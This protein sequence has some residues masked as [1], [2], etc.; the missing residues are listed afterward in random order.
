VKQNTSVKLFPCSFNG[1]VKVPPSKSL[2]HRALICAALSSGESLITNFVYSEDTLATIEALETLGVKFERKDN[3][4]VVHGIKKLKLKSKKVYCNE[5]GSTIRFLIPLFSLTEK[6]IHFIGEPG[7]MKRP[8]SIYEK[9]FTEDNN[10][11]IQDDEKIVVKGSVKAR[12]YTIKG[13]VSSQ[14]FSGLMFA[15][16][17][18][19]EDSEIIIDGI[20]ESKSYID[21]TIKT[22]EH[23]GVTIREIPKGYFIEGNQSYVAND[24]RVEGDYSQAAFHLVGGIIG[25]AIKVTDVPHDSSQG[26]MAIIDII[27]S[28]KGK[29]IFTENGFTTVKSKTIGRVIDIQNC[30]DLGPIVSLL[31]ALSKGTTKIVN[32]HRLR[33]KESDRIE[34]TV[35]TLAKLGANIKVIDDEIIIVG[36]KSLDGPGGTFDSFNDHRIAMM[37]GIASSRCE[38]PFTIKHADCI[39]KS[40]PHFFEDLKAIGG[41]V[42]YE[43]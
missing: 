14:F 12:K 21:L 19:D 26:D 10:T 39:N 18:L 32:A 5:S 40:Y 8:Q 13:D 16:P 42:V 30:P 4:V 34:S 38:V 7:L 24:Y 20:L 35:T 2:S 22:L 15:L 37:L 28:M 9:I 25:G 41:K 33:L 29:I 27:Q 31:A 3:K 36:K 6:E 43:E 17:L 1:T 23:F 11:F